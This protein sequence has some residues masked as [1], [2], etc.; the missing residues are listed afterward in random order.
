MPW[1][2]SYIVFVRT[3][4]HRYAFVTFKNTEQ[5]KQA[6][7]TLHNKSFFDFTLRVIYS[8]PMERKPL[9]KELE[10]KT[11]CLTL[12][13]LKYDVDSRDIEEFIVEPTGAV[14]VDVQIL[15]N[16]KGFRYGMAKVVFGSP[17]DAKK[18]LKGCNDKLLSG[19]PIHV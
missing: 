1:Y 15:E 18:A 2:E 6:V 3:T 19:R 16:D 4:K 5:S 13:N 14:P 7:D 10:G 12:S 11:S 8:K 9:R 17:E